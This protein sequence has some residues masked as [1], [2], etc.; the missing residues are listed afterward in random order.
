M[1]TVDKR[2]LK[3]KWEMLKWRAEQKKREAKRFCQE[4]PEAAFF[5]VTT[6]VGGVSYGG[7]KIINAVGAR[8]E[9]KSLECRHYDRRT[10]TYWFSKRPLKISE[11]LELEK[12]YSEGL[13]KGEILR[14]MG[15]L[16]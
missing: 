15:L 3:E 5:G 8:R 10:D 4:H 13:G 16:K 1:E 6:L 14:Q 7:K 2:T 11:K 9:F 12:L